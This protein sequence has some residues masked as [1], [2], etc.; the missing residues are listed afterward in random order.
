MRKICY[1]IPKGVHRMAGEV[2]I[3]GRVVAIG[4]QAIE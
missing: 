3:G 4:L 2:H 1:C